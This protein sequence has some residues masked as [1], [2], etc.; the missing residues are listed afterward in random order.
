MF[1]PQ[2]RVEPPRIMKRPSVPLKMH[3]SFRNKSWERPAAPNTSQINQQYY[4]KLNTDERWKDWRQ[5]YNE[6]QL[7]PVWRRISFPIEW[8]RLW[9][10]KSSFVKIANRSYF[11]KLEHVQL[12][13]PLKAFHKCAAFISS[14][15]LQLC[16]GNFAINFYNWDHQAV[17]KL[18]V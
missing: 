10:F 6:F 16:E 4:I 12:V 5:G 15:M 8:R 2:F 13:L 9:H 17:L 14:G 1:L 7:S 11:L 3:N 18:A